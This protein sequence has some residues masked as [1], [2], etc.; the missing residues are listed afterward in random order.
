MKN[1]FCGEGRGKRLRKI[2]PPAPPPP[3]P[4]KGLGEG[5]RATYEKY[6]KYE[7]PLAFSPKIINPWKKSRS[8]IFG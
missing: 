4:C 8:G 5:V 3:N 6:E 7:K 1:K 2:P